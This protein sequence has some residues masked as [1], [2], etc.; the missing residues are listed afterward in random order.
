L[1]AA[2]GTKIW[3]Y[4]TGSP[5]ESFPSIANGVLYIG[6]DDNNVY[7]FG[8]I[9]VPQPSPPLPSP[10]IPEIAPITITIILIAMTTT[11]LLLKRISRLQIVN[12]F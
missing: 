10:T 6:S 8:S 7:A 9:T 5:V 4:T 1:D 11:I 12:V 3:S 2:K